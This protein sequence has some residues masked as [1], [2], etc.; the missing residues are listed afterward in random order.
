MDSHDPITGLLRHPF[1]L[2][3]LV[4]AISRL[5]S[6]R[7]ASRSSS[8]RMGDTREIATTV[9]GWRDSSRWRRDQSPV[10]TPSPRSHPLWD[11]EL[12]G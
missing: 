3:A 1:V 9:S 6:S 8:N 10:P 2:W 7:Q 12:D 5:F 4:W 11:R